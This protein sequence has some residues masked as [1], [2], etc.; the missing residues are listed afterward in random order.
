[1][2]TKSNLHKRIV[3]GGKRKMSFKKDIDEIE[4]IK[5][6]K[7]SWFE[8]A[9]PESV[10]SDKK[11]GL[12]EKEVLY[13]PADV[14][15]DYLKDVSIPGEYP[16]TRGIYPKM[17]SD[18]RFWAMRQVSGYG[19][20]EETR[21]RLNFLFREGETQ[22]AIVGD[23]PTREGLDSDSP[24]AEGEV[25]RLGVPIDSIEDIEKVFHGLPLETIR[26]G[27]IESASGT[28][29][30]LSM[31][32]AM[33]QKKGISLERLAGTIQNDPLTNFFCSE[34]KLFPPKHSMRIVSDIF[35]FCSNYVPKWTTVN[36]GGRTMRDL[37]ITAAEELGITMVFGIAYIEAAVSR[38]LDID[39]FAP[40]VAHY[41]STHTNLL[42]EVAK[43]RAARRMWARITKE[44]FGAKDP[45]SMMCKYHV[46]TCS[47]IL[48]PQQPLNNIIR[49][50]IQG[51][52][53]V[54]GGTQSLDVCSYDEAMGL[55]TEESV[56]LSLRTQQIIAY[57]S[58][59][60]DYIDPL[61]GSYLVEHLT[62]K[63]ENEANE[64]IRKIEDLGGG[65]VL[66]GL[67]KAI[68][69]GTLAREFTDD[70]LND[71][72]KIFSGEKIVVGVNK[73]VEEDDKFTSEVFR[74]DEESEKRQIENLRRIK[75]DRN[76]SL[77]RKCL[78]EIKKAAEGQVNLVTPTIEAVKNSATLGEVV[79]ALESVFGSF[80]RPVTF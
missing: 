37:G 80:E 14:K 78:D 11:S 70:Y 36:I 46:K 5:E 30:V 19:T 71:Q 61:A 33:A 74:V 79:E 72:K 22:L 12:S 26:P 55:P 44:R 42:E 73:F 31:Y 1:M 25:G 60:T 16:F 20:P 67:I 75:R 69:I 38:G 23:I 17:Y 62:N 18:K 48:T 40:G 6:R 2:F 50:T 54:L 59:I 63:I 4:E 34:L 56:K 51:L 43:L 68:E 24:M 35:E 28:I 39:S 52:A 7:K 9:F 64:M 65:S 49:G 29:A 13:T 45:K 47:L 27:L 66:K 32:F 15:V 77:V 10:A 8:N 41:Y 76:N 3:S 53:A 57:E 58:D 21:K